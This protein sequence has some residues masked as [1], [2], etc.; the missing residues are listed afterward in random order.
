[1]TR[2][3]RS[4]RGLL[5][6]RAGE[7]RLVVMLAGLF[8]TVEA[9][10]GLGEVAADTMFISRYGA[11]NLPY[12]YIGLGILSLV[13]A[14]GYGAAIGRLPRRTLFIALLG[15]FAAILVAER[16]AIGAFPEAIVPVTWLTVY[17][18]TALLITVV[19]T[20][21]SGTLDAR[22]AKR[23]FPICTS[24]AIAG[25]FA[26]TLAAGPLARLVG[27]ENLIALFAALI[28]VAAA[29]TASIVG[30]FGKVPAVRREAGSVTAELRAGFDQVRA[31]PLMRLVA[32]AYV[33]LAILLFSV[34]FPFMQAVGA[35]YPDPADLATALGLLSAAVTAASFLASMLVANRLYARFGVVAAALLLPI[36]YLGGF[37]L[38]LVQ[39]NLATAVVFRFAQQVTQRGLSN[40]AWSAL[41]AVLPPDRRPQVMAFIDGVPGQLGTVLSGVLL[42]A[43]A[44]LLAPMQIFVLGALTAAACTWVVLQIRRRYGEALV[45][46]LRAGLAEQVLEGGHDLVALCRDPQVIADLRDALTAEQPGARRLAAELLGRLA[47][48]AAS[49]GLAKA[50]SDHD[51]EVRAAAIAGLASLASVAGSETVER[52]AAVATAA[53]ADPMPA[54]RIAAVRAAP[55]A[56]LDSEMADTL[57]ADPDP[58]VRAEVAIALAGAGNVAAASA[59]LDALL[60]GRP[61]P[62]R[63]AGLAAIA[64]QPAGLGSGREVESFLTDSSIDVRVAAVTAVG[65]TAGTAALPAA[66]VAALDDPAPAVRR[67]ASAAIR[68]ES[69]ARHDGWEAVVAVLEAGSGRA[70]DAALAALSAV[71]NDGH[72]TLVRVREWAI[73]QAGR[74]FDLRRRAGALSA[75]GATDGAA[76]PAGGSGHESVI[77]F[78]RELLER[79]GRQIEDRLLAAIATLGNPEANGPIR[80]S[81]RSRDPDVRAQAIEALDAMSDRQLA[82]AVVRL[83]DADAAVIPDDT[84]GTLRALCDDPDPWIRRLALRAIADRLSAEWQVLSARAANDPDPIVRA[85]LTGLAKHGGQAMPDTEPTL[86]EIDRMMFLRRVPLFG[87]LAAEDLHRIAE[88]SVERIYAPDE[89]L[90]REGDVGDELVVIVEGDVRV[91]HGDGPDARVVRTYEAGDHIGELAVL[92]ERPRA[93]TVIAGAAGVRGLVISGEGLRSILTERPEAAMAMLATLAERISQQ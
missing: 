45:R 60:V 19:W 90:V 10:R 30:R 92:R 75:D 34:T 15:T 28:V 41:Y 6:V 44:G 74:A 21:A 5:A 85:A 49:D 82:R 65:A 25:G 67:A 87:Q 83:L 54:V 26:G 3:M 59:I 18:V 37:G 33:L 88:T 22:Q 1:M 53:M 69:A 48:P 16:L 86:G 63:V 43:I 57:A 17:V 46:T 32:I 76:L 50:A 70:Q 11:A 71:G 39:F 31:S 42:L 68:D 24:A 84:A 29:L 79:R 55:V 91:V 7:G 58:G 66:L 35:A 20:V 52:S 4:G 93:A 23:L 14:L 77:G 13:V 12:L 51:P 62:E 81:L 2:Q 27:V 40:A 38:W 8:A 78:L 73:G 9:G 36:V 56:R 89:A 61:A 64:R 47:D 80:R 72:E